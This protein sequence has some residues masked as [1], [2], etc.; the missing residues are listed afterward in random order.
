[1]G[2]SVPKVNLSITIHQARIDYPISSLLISPQ[3]SL[4]Y[5][6]N[7]IRT[8]VV[9]SIL[10]IW[11]ETFNFEF[12]TGS[13]MITLLNNPP[14][15]KETTVGNCLI[16]LNNATGW[17]ELKN[18]NEKVGAVRITVKAE[19]SDRDIQKIYIEKIKEIK[20]EQEE[21]CYLKKKYAS[22]LQKLKNAENE[23][24]SSKENSLS[25]E[26]IEECSYISSKS[27]QMCKDQKE[28]VKRK[29]L[30]RIQEQSLEQEKNKL[31]E[32]WAQIDKEKEEIE[33]MKNKL[34]EGYSEFQ[35]AK[36]RFALQNRISEYSKPKVLTPKSCKSTR[37]SENSPS[38]PQLSATDS[39]LLFYS[40]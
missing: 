5:N 29:S 20:V 22:K 12:T 9:H 17:F 37:L 27:P 7:S 33:E 19:L 18:S 39:D 36:H 31:R 14:L 1:M 28:I 2:E 30:L 21:L 26:G 16:S 34:K 35:I 13:C 23:L 38:N 8:K 25:K 15:C 4:S 3:L 40:R 11:N 10:P 32:A 24:I 6:G